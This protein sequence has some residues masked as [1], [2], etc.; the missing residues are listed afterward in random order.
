MRSAHYYIDSRL[1]IAL[2]IND[3]CASRQDREL[4]IRSDEETLCHPSETVH[5][6]KYTG[7]SR[8]C[9]VKF[10]HDVLYI[11]KSIISRTCTD[12]IIFI[13]ACK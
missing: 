9:E 5:L 8:E 10:N 13:D 6:Y 4:L 1:F 3:A 2:R 11:V 7:E 12:R